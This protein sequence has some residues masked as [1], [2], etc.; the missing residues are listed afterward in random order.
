ML[1][2]ISISKGAKTTFGQIPMHLGNLKL[3]VL[4]L[5]NMKVNAALLKVKRSSPKNIISL[6]KLAYKPSNKRG[7]LLPIYLENANTPSE[8]A[9][10]LATTLHASLL[11]L[12]ETH[13]IEKEA[14]RLSV[15]LI[16]MANI[17]PLVAV[18]QT[19]IQLPLTEN[20]AIHYVVYH[21]RYPL[22]IRSHLESHLDTIL[23]RKDETA[24]WNHPKVSEK[25][26]ASPDI[27][28]HIFVVLSS[29]VAE[30]GRDHDYDWAIVEPS[31][32]RSIIQLAGRVLRH[33]PW[34][35]VERPNIF[36]LH[37][38]FKGLQGKSPCFSRPGFESSSLRVS[39]SDLANILPAEA[40]EVINSCERI[41]S[42]AHLT[43]S[44]EKTLISI[45]HEA[46]LKTLIET[47]PN[48]PVCIA[49]KWWEKHP[50]WNANLQVLQRFRA[51]APSENY[52]LIM[53]HED[54]DPTWYKIDPSAINPARKYAKTTDISSHALTPEQERQ[55]WFDLNASTIMKELYHILSCPKPS[56]ETMTKRYAES[57]LINYSNDNT[58]D[59][60]YHPQLGTFK[61]I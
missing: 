56:Y 17:D 16:R 38:N 42:G 30:V 46:T 7:E 47:N 59:W 13:A 53:Q 19:L 52:C 39:S 44:V 9:E 54:D 20:T 28:N 45:E 24:I 60:K 31:S 41:R 32:L 33:R 57:S 36:I 2:S 1:Y 21:S 37:H 3:P 14:R 10:Q 18:A 25:L 29:P 48:D 11:S 6:H 23:S 40:Y 50:T 5:M 12:H 49:S 27:Q 58:P 51:S 15:G 34:K 22:A 35:N 26:A 4:G 61:K 43:A 55:F 8:V